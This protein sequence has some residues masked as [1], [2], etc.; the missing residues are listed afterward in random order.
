MKSKYKH[1]AVIT[2]STIGLT[3]L[4]SAA[5]FGDEKYTYD[6]SGNIIEK[7]I[8]GQ[9][10]KRAYDG[11][12]KVISIDSATKGGESINYDAAGRP[13]SYKDAAGQAIR[14]LSYGYA[15]KVLKADNA[16]SEA[17]F[18]YN[19]EGQLVG[20]TVG[21]KLTPYTWDGN[22]L[23]AEGA[24]AFTNEAHITGGVPAM[25]GDQTVVISDYLGNTLS[26]G[27][28]VVG[29]QMNASLTV[30][31]VVNGQQLKADLE[32][33]QIVTTTKAYE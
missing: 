7:S 4:A 11:S 5:N 6:G 9:V 1:W 32:G 30:F 27:E 2:A 23:A 24:D 12:N 17:E 20:K 29:E 26:Q 25:A 16:G 15:D 21:G 18:F 10:T 33:N 31:K 8:N 13:V 19:A 22:V 3:G 14:Q 28:Q